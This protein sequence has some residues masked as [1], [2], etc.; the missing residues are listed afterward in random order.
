MASVEILTICF[1]FRSGSS[2]GHIKPLE[3][4]GDKF[5]DSP[6][7]P[8]PPIQG[9]KPQWGRLNKKCHYRIED[10]Y[11]MQNTAV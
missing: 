9:S 5:S 6:A 1:C 10:C 11:I 4:I 2:S 3:K 7:T 8:M